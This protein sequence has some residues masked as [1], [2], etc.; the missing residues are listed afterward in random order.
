MIELLKPDYASRLL[1]DC[2]Q[3]LVV[4]QHLIWML[5]HFQKMNGTVISIGDDDRLVDGHHRCTLVVLTGRSLQVHF[6]IQPYHV[7]RFIQ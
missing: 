1:K 3:D 4:H 6:K 2:A 5:E 7:E